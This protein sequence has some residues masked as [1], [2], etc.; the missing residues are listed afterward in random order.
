MAQAN[1]RAH[2]PVATASEV[3][4]TSYIPTDLAR[5]SLDSMKSK[6]SEQRH[7]FQA[8]LRD[9]VFHYKRQE[10]AS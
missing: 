6:M 9:V 1:A 2:P 7:K 10:E 5:S 3:Q 8:E 4:E